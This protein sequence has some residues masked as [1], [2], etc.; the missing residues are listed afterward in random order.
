VSKLIDRRFVD[1]AI[2]DLNVKGWW[3]DPPPST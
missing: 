3:Q 1:Q 2:T